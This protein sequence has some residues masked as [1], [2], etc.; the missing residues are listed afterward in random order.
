MLGNTYYYTSGLYIFPFSA[1]R[2]RSRA[3]IYYCAHVY[4]YYYNIHTVAEIIVRKI[5]NEYK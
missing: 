2:R 4:Y 5:L 1:V 3:V